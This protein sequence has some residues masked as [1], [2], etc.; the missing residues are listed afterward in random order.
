MISLENFPNFSRRTESVNFSPQENQSGKPLVVYL[1]VYLSSTSHYTQ[2]S[3]DKHL[4]RGRACSNLQAFSVQ[5]P[6]W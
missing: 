1:K 4:R 6:V 2:W 3:A 5:V